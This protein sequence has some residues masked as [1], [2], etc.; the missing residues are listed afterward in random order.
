MNGGN[1][2]VKMRDVL[3]DHAWKRDSGNAAMCCQGLLRMEPKL[4]PLSTQTAEMEV[5]R[6]IVEK[7]SRV[8]RE[9][10]TRKERD[11]WLRRLMEKMPDN[12]C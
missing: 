6:S 7:A 2:A 5:G 9:P 11:E 8:K 1:V 10:P 3:P 4:S 12:G